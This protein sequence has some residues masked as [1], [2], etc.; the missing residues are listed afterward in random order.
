VLV[1]DGAATVRGC[2]G[3]AVCPVTSRRLCHARSGF[4]PAKWHPSVERLTGPYAEN[5]WTTRY[6]GPLPTRRPSFSI[7]NIIIMS[8]ERTPDAKDTRR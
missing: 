5:A 2:R 8:I 7:S 4:K 6:A 1:R 3:L